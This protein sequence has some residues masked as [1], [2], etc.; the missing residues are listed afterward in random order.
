MSVSGQ[1]RPGVTYELARVYVKRWA[2]E[3]RMAREKYVIVLTP[4]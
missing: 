1:A 4:L 3:S 2:S